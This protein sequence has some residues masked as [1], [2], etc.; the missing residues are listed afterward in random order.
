MPSLKQLEDFKNSFQNIG[1]EPLVLA[2]EHLP[3]TGFPLP[4][5]EPAVPPEEPAPEPDSALSEPDSNF[6]P[7]PQTP[8]I[9]AEAVPDNF[10]FGAFLDTIPDDLSMP[11][12]D[13]PNAASGGA[14]PEEADDFNFPDT[15]LDGFADEIE[16]EQSQPDPPGAS[17]DAFPGFSIPETPGEPAEGEETFPDFD[18][19]DDEMVSLFSEEALSQTG[20]KPSEPEIPETPPEDSFDAFAE[21]FDETAEPMEE[22]LSESIGETPAPETDDMDF[23]VPETGGAETDGMDFSI[24]ETGGTETDTMDFSIPETG[25]DDFFGTGGET[26]GGPSGDAVPDSFDTFN[27]DANVLPS[28]LADS[29]DKAAGGEEFGLEE[30]SLAGIDDVF[31]A[32]PGGAPLPAAGKGRTGSEDVEEIN[33]SEKEL[34]QLQQT[35]A[36]YPLNLRIACEE[37]IAEQAVAPDLMAS[38]VKL[39]VRGAPAR[40]TASLAGKILGRTIPIPKGFEKK[41]GE[42][43][44]A[45][46][47]S[48]PYVFVHKFLPVLRLFLGIALVTLSLFYLAYKF[49]YI[50]VRANS[51]YAAGY[52]RIEAGDYSRAKER[53]NEAL[54]IHRV[55][56]W[57]Y[58]YAE[59]FRDA[60]QYIPAEEKYDELLFYYPRDKK[61]ALD[62]AS[63]ETYYLRNYDKADT[64]L[65]RNILDYAVDDKEGLLAL[66]DNYLAWGE[67]DKAKYEDARAAYAR[68]LE[69]YGWED[70]IVERMMIY[71]IRTGNLK[72]VL[73]LQRF[74]MDNKKKKIS[75]STLAELGGYLLDKRL[76][77]ARGVPDEFIDRIDGIRDI[78]L[79][80]VR[81]DPALPESYYHL[82]R[83]YH[84]YGGAGEERTTLESAV[85]AFDS[86]LPETPRRTRY[87]IDAERRYAQILIKAREFFA[88]EKELVKGIDIYEDAVSR[89]LL[90]RSPDFGRLYADLG[91]L[92]YFTGDEDMETTL[93]YYL[94]SEQ[95]GWAPPEIQYRMGSAY[96]HQRQWAP[97]LERFFL[98]FSELPLNR[99]I[100]HAL[101]N[102]SYMRGN[103]FAAQAYYNQLLDLL[104]AERAR[105]PMLMPNDR[106][107]HMELAERLMVA[108]NNLGVT[109]EALAE[110]TGNT[111]YRSR[112]LA[113]YAESARAWDSITRNP[114]TMIRMRP[115][116][117]YGPGINLGFL[118]S[119][120][121]LH[122]TP[123]YEPQIFIQI[124]KDVLEPSAWEDL[125][126]PQYRL[127][128][129]P[130]AS[131][132]E[133]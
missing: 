9:R 63:M 91:D 30:F 22:L 23:S 133:P 94:R 115:A 65:K 120:N 79:K 27:L 47:A 82:S 6:Y 111:S 40:E 107:E 70:P 35:L 33:L 121:T 117:L 75:A 72:E 96:Y 51:I 108:R 55:K 19:P 89:R 118:N 64:I 1:N 73:P 61:G 90:A 106:P 41:T 125:R 101:G 59:A 83:Y 112:A 77:E 60:R 36:V 68:L 8:D 99:R 24:P 127:S 52:E 34:N 48:F 54:A 45:E 5:S 87:R 7:P 31:A 113:L 62:Y 21:P 39:L 102:A 16:A 58:R 71:F 74:F 44:E 84:R 76:E 78:L 69:Q 116:N 46:Q 56:K 10:D 104:E 124:D 86:A 53:F 100:L 129:N 29:T 97:A 88:A 123:G 20:E 109:L 81:T 25:G 93:R 37:L 126:P 114:E 110:N 50:P 42:D 32:P 105:F 17:E 28:D 80:A 18:I 128:G 103:Y 49:I 13:V 122:P 2:E 92:A 38:L 43:L 67:I 131:L 130:P 119:Q 15:L 3:F 26:M 11:P 14:A 85:T 66:G 98:V 12:P 95:N 4:D 132:A 57:F